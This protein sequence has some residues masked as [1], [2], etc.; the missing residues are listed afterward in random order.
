[1]RP[2]LGVINGKEIISIKELTDLEYQEFKIATQNLTL[3]STD[4]QLYSIVNWNHRDYIEL[5][6]KY[7]L[8]Y[9]ERRS[10]V[11]WAHG[12]NMVINVNRHILNFL[13]S[14]RTFLDHSETN[15]KKRYG[16]EST[17]YKKFKD[18]CSDVY[19]N[20]FSYRFLY[21]LRNYAQHC[22]MPVGSLNLN[23]KVINQKT[24]ETSESI[25]LLFNRDDLLQNYDSWGAK[26]SEELRQLPQKF[27]INPHMN[28]VMKSIEHINILLIEEELPKLLK[29]AKDLQEFL[30]PIEGNYGRPCILRFHDINGD[31]QKLNLQVEWIPLHLVEMILNNVNEE[32]FYD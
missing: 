7:Y 29:S 10:N 26:L 25:E 3:F 9:V 15:F 30:K 23:S 13:S 5:L 18:A 11:E 27:V 31:G 32:Y 4:Q 19:D 28:E 24:S 6:H 14:V 22:G 17:K 21:K 16:I 1:M 8:E 12:Q 20:S 2:K